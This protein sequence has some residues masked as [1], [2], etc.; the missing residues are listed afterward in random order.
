MIIGN[1][2]LDNIKP[3]FE[4]ITNHLFQGLS[5]ISPCYIIPKKQRIFVLILL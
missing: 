4:Y 2:F 5:H 1:S 3:I